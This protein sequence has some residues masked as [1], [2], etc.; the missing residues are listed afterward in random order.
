MLKYVKINEDI[1]KVKQLWHRFGI[2]WA[3]P[4]HK[5]KK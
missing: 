3:E 4:L 5:T 1:Y 2:V